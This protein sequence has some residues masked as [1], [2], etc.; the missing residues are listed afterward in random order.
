MSQNPIVT[1][2][3]INRN[4]SVTAA[5]VIKAVPGLVGT[6]IVDVAGSGGA[7]TL[8]D[9]ATV[10]AAGAGNQ[11]ASIANASIVAGVPYSFFWPCKTGIVIS[12]VPTGS[13]VRISFT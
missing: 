8:N 9:C 11:V 5:A 10:G 7:L 6:I 1:T 4:R 3:I 13:T 2:D 12:A